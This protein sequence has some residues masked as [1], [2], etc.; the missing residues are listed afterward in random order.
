MLGISKE[1][2][3]ALPEV[4]YP[5]RVILIDSAAKAKDAVAYLMKQP[6]IGFDTETRPSFQKNHRYK[7]SLVQ[8]SVPGECF[9]FRL[10]QI[11]S[12]DGLMSI[13]ENPAI[14]KIGLSLK[15][16]FH[17][18]AKLCEFTPAGFVELQT[19]VKEYEIAD[20]SLQKIFALIFGQRISKNQ[21]LTNWE[22]PELTPSQ[23][24]YAAIDAWA[25]VE[26]YNHLCAGN[27]HPE[28]SPYNID[29][30]TALMLQSSVGIHLPLKHGGDDG[31]AAS[32]TPSP[33][34]AE[35]TA[36]NGKPVKRRAPRPTKSVKTEKTVKSTR[37]TKPTKSAK[38]TKAVNSD[39]PAKPTPSSKETNGSKPSKKAAKPTGK[40]A[41]SKA[42]TKA[43]DV[44]T[45]PPKALPSKP[46]AT[47]RKATSAKKEGRPADDTKKSVAAKKK[48][49]KKSS[50]PVAVESIKQPDE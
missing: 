5:G 21:R 17:S 44:K 15:D 4:H 30:Q 24:S 28:E 2:V 37:S 7:V 35:S 22:A 11:G 39:K 12:L 13:F 16:D 33:A 41:S 10:K 1:T 8:L 43:K 19:F 29:D 18:L 32:D 25:C 3:H 46:K 49:M 27:F 40:K 38:S 50:T 47:P 14:Q 31:A 9:L 26:I 42:N 36:L 34:I 23:Q 48:R 6:Q 20:N 45:A